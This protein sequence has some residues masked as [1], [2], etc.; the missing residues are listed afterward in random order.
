M[1]SLGLLMSEEL[2]DGWTAGRSLT[3][4]S[5]GELT[6]VVVSCFEEVRVSG[7]TTGAGPTSAW[8][9]VLTAT[10]HCQ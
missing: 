3:V 8:T 2:S 7:S 10:T 9:S 6:S 1:L 4:D 5:D